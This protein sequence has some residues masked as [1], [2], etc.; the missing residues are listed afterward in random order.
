M[1][2]VVT[3]TTVSPELDNHGDN[4]KARPFLTYIMCCCALNAFLKTWFCC[5]SCGANVF[6]V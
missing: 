4:V 2:Q 5:I 6:H 3:A 1:Q